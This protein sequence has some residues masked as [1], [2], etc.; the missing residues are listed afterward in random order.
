MKSTPDRARVVEL[1]AALSAAARD[2][3]NARNRARKL[4]ARGLDP[5]SVP[6]AP[7]CDLAARVGAV[8]RAKEAK[9]AAGRPPELAADELAAVLPGGR[10]R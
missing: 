9:L 1:R 5:A 10:V 6:P 2:L 4:R 8:R 3:A 7:P